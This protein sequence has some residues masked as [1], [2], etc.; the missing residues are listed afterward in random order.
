[1][2][3][4]FLRSALAFGLAL[5]SAVPSRSS[6]DLVDCPA[7]EVSSSTNQSLKNREAESLFAD[8]TQAGSSGNNAEKLNHSKRDTGEGGRRQLA[9]GMTFLA[10][11]AWDGAI[12]AFSKAAD[13]E[14]FQVALEARSELARALNAKRREVAQRQVELGA[15]YLGAKAWDEAIAAASKAADSDDPQVASEGRSQLASAVDSKRDERGQRQLELGSTYLDGGAWDEAIAASSK[16]ADFE[17]SKVASKGRSQLLNALK[18]K[19]AGELGFRAWLPAPFNRWWILDYL[20][21]ALVILVL[22]SIVIPIWAL[23]HR[24][25]FRRFFEFVVKRDRA[26]SPW[27]VSVSGSAEEPLRS[28]VFD[29][30]VVTMKGLRDLYRKRFR[31]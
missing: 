20:V 21:Y 7:I 31:R 16:A 15:T 9:I 19:N 4:G 17:D 30:F 10:A 29:E 25:I 3:T 22:G 5:S 6:A 12:A 26:K 18:A 24:I 2:G 27:R 8:A 1:M 23:G 11:G 13:S 14:D 28:V